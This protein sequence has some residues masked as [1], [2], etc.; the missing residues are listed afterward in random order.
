[1]LIPEAKRLVENDPNS[2]TIGPIEKR[3]MIVSP[4]VTQ[5]VDGLQNK[6]LVKGS[7]YQ[8]INGKT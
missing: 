3:F 8:Y 6:E 1:M 2:K 5:I 4:S 7:S